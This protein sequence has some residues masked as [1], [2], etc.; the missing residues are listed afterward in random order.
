MSGLAVLRERDELLTEN[1]GEAK[2]VHQC[3]V[4]L[5]RNLLE[6]FPAVLDAQRRRNLR[7][8]LFELLTKVE[9]LSDGLFLELEAL[10][11]YERI[12]LFEKRLIGTDS[13]VNPEGRALV[14]GREKGRSVLVGEEDH[15]RIQ[16]S[17]VSLDLEEAFVCADSLD[18]SLEQHCRFAFSEEFGYLTSCPSE[19]G[20]GLLASTILHLPALALLGELPKVIRGLL[21]L[22]IAIRS[23]FRDSQG[24]PGAWLLISNSRSL[25]SPEQDYVDSLDLLA[26]KLL[27]FEERA[28]MKARGEAWSLLE[29]EV[30]KAMEALA[31]IEKITSLQAVASLGTLRLGAGVGLL[32]QLELSRLGS[33][34]VGIQPGHLQMLAGRA[35]NEEERAHLRAER[36]KDWL[37]I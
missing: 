6:P 26:R 7:A 30:N 33:I 35:L 22:K 20:T 4:T 16:C 23:T 36:L 21:A 29:D 11:H 10:E 5:K 31:T 27:T 32:P 37:H 9:S 2:E 28:Q 19:A 34:E 1:P 18:A 8:R 24:A 17:R 25:G 15:L 12:Y 13:L 3:W 14:I